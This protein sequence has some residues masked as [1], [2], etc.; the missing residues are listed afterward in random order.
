MEARLKKRE[1]EERGEREG[2]WSGNKKKK[3]NILEGKKREVTGKGREGGENG[4]EREGRERR[5]GKRRLVWK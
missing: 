3:R 4:K 2:D 5:E 1:K